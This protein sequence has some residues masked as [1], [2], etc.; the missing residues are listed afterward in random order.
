MLLFILLAH[1][2]FAQENDSDFEDLFDEMDRLEAVAPDS[3]SAEPSTPP[4]GSFPVEA[5]PIAEPGL[6]ITDESFEDIFAEPEIIVED[7]PSQPVDEPPVAE[8][9]PEPKVIVSEE[10]EKTQEIQ[11][12]QEATKTIVEEAPE[13]PVQDEPTL[14]FEPEPEQLPSPQPTPELP[15][16]FANQDEIE[17]SKRL[18]EFVRSGEPSSEEKNFFKAYL[19]NYSKPTD[20][21]V[22]TALTEMREDEKYVVQKGDTLW[23]LSKTFFGDGFFWPKLWSVNPDFKNPHE[24]QKMDVIVFN[25]GNLFFEPSIRVDNESSFI[26]EFKDGTEDMSEF[27]KRNLRL[28]PPVKYRQ[29]LAKIPSSFAPITTFDLGDRNNFAE[30]VTTNDRRFS[31]DVFTVLSRVLSSPLSGIGT[32]VGV[33]NGK[34]AIVNDLVYVQLLQPA[35]PNQMLYVVESKGTLKAQVGRGYIFEYGGILQVQNTVD[36]EKNLYSA[37]VKKNFSQLGVGAT[38]VVDPPSE[39]DLKVSRANTKSIARILGGSLSTK[40]VAFGTGGV[41]FVAG[42]QDQG[43]QMGDQL[44]IY[45]NPTLR[46]QVLLGNQLTRTI[47][48]AQVVHVDKNHATLL[49]RESETVVFSGDYVGGPVD[50]DSTMIARKSAL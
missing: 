12:A 9:L 31:N 16:V 49:I 8:V 19:S 39:V 36:A 45:M 30:S 47:G 10:T 7:R 21:A 20:P 34:T 44:K 5:D 15:P 1:L 26:T 24:I 22:W 4:A 33:E 43:F 25:P 28:P 32:V 38:V 6:E 13:L 14:V 50:V 23:D 41:I 2:S 18:E 42:G 37:V 46:S 35:S 48:L 3:T 29:P 11:E 40:R 17:K 27:E